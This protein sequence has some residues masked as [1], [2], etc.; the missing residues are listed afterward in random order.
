M[1]LS[2]IQSHQQVLNQRLKDGTSGTPSMVF[3]ALGKMYVLETPFNNDS[4][5]YYLAM[6]IRKLLSRFQ[7]NYYF[8]CLEVWISGNPNARP[9]TAS[10]RKEAMVLTSNNGDGDSMDVWLIHR[11]QQGKPYVTEPEKKKHDVGTKGLF[12]DLLDPKPYRSLKSSEK[13]KADK[14]FN[15]IMKMLTHRPFHN[16]VH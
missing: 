9:S 5:K 15:K 2:Q 4:E 6:A 7:A 11:D 3:E 10:D 8:L 16:K 1:K 13:R 12:V 14:V